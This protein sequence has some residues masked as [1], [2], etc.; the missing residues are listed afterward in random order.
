MENFSNRECCD[1]DIRDYYTNVPVMFI[2]YCNTTTH[3]FTSDSIYA[4]INGDKFIQ[5]T[6][7]GNGTL[8]LSF[9]VRPFE[10][11][12]LLNGEKMF[13]D[14]IIA[15]HEDIIAKENGYLELSYQ[16]ILGTVFVYSN[17][18]ISEIGGNYHDKKFLSTDIELGKSYSVCYLE[19]KQDGVKRITFNNNDEV[20]TYS[21]KMFTLNKSECGD[22]IVMQL[23]AYKCI[24]NRELEINFS[25]NDSPAEIT[26]SFECLQ[27]ENENVIDLIE[28][29]EDIQEEIW[30]NFKKG[31][32]ET[33]SSSFYIKD[34]YLYQIQE[35]K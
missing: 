10:I 23:I 20:R 34:G 22:S 25:S 30:I 7:P 3:D 13:T 19:S 11:F 14:A 5:Y 6:A 15:R 4:R 24:P 16:P 9:Q 21:I 18:D 32:L 27:D 1:V 12:T 28:V 35:D 33:T 26:I 2:D 8:E 17:D 29:D 31:T